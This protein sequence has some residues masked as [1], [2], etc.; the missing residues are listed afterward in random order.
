MVEHVLAKTNTDVKINVAAS[1]TAQSRILRKYRQAILS[2][3]VLAVVFMMAW[4]GNG[5]FETFHAYQRGYLAIFL[6]LATLWYI[7]L[8]VMMRR[9]NVSRLTPLQLYKAT[10]RMKIFTLCGEA[11]AAIGLAVFF[12]LFTPDLY[13]AKP[14][15][16]WCVVIL[17]GVGFASTVFYYLPKYLR[18]FNALTTVSDEH[19]DPGSALLGGRGTDSG[20][21]SVRA[22]ASGKFSGFRGFVSRNAAAVVG[23]VIASV[24]AVAAVVGV[25]NVS[26]SKSGPVAIADTVVASDATAPSAVVAEEN[27]EEPAS[28]EIIV[29]DNEPFE[30]IIGEIAKYYGYAVN[31]NTDSS[32]ALRLYF[33]WNQELPLDEVVES[34]NNF[35][36]IHIT[37]EGETINID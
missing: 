31:F 27:E 32:K 9:I 29:Y 36:Q 12:A 22:G 17:V 34:L 33:R 23:V 35:E 18:L 11:F 8:Y 7:F 24:V 2:S 19:D 21:E 10:T 26:S 25:R 1:K 13:S 4:L 16:F 14:F 30:S 5:M 6:T 37:L 20:E 15:A 3:G 28:P